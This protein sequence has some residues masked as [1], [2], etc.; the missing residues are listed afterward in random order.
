VIKLRELRRKPRAVSG[1]S[2]DGLVMIEDANARSK[3]TEECWPIAE[4]LRVRGEPL[5]LQGAPEGLETAD[6]KAA[7]ALLDAL[8]A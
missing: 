7:N 4:L 2:P 6:L 8:Q 5:L 3:R 1:R